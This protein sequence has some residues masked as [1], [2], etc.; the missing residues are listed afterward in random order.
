MGRRPSQ[1]DGERKIDEP[2]DEQKKKKEEEEAGDLTEAS[3]C[4][5]FVTNFSKKSPFWTRMLRHNPGRRL[6]SNMQMGRIMR[7]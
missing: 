5:S 4:F 1:T 7:D 2:G 3:I 6:L